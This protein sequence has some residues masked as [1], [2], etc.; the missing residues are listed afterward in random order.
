MWLDLEVMWWWET[1]SNV[2][3]P[4]PESVCCAVLVIANRRPD[5]SQ[6]GPFSGPERLLKRKSPLRTQFQLSRP[7]GSSPAKCAPSSERA[8][9]KG[10]SATKTSVPSCK[11][12]RV[13][14]ILQRILP[15]LHLSPDFPNGIRL[16]TRKVVAVTRGNS[17]T[18]PYKGS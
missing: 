15:P 13:I 18:H 10:L 16:Q 7:P 3:A 5:Y 9:H 14:G 11:S 6:Q 2:H 12:Q 17:M 4:H 1:T 8:N